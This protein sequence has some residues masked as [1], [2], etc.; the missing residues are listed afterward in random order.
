MP[1]SESKRVTFRDLL[2]Y[3]VVMII[4]VVLYFV[5]VYPKANPNTSA[6]LS[7]KG[8]LTYQAPGCDIKAPNL[9]STSKEYYVPG[10]PGYDKLNMATI[11]G[12]RWFC[13]EQDAVRNGWT[14]AK[15]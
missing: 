13:S 7:A 11:L 14:K 4:F 3:F 5:F 15:S 10:Q 8:E 1:T 2:P 12:G 6:E 9:S